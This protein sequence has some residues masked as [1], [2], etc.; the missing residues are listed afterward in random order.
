MKVWLSKISC[1]KSSHVSSR[2]HH[3][4]EI[5]CIDQQKAAWFES[6]L[7]M[8][9]VSCYTIEY[10]WLHVTATQHEDMREKGWVLSQFA[11]KYYWISIKNYIYVVKIGQQDLIMNNQYPPYC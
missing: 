10:L 7:Y 5:L 6:D 4:T 8:C 9:D 2:R 11:F 1:S 3:K